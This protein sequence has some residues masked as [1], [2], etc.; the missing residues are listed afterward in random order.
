MNV[1]ESFQESVG[2]STWTLS[3]CQ[4]TFGIKMENV[5]KFE[6]P[7]YYSSVIFKVEKFIKMSIYS[8]CLFDGEFGATNPCANCVSE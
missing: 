4:G 7:L 1:T 2:L 3:Q 6:N 5:S 8:S